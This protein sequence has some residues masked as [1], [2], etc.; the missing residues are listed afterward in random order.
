VLG[1]ADADAIDPD[2]PFADIGFDSLT[3]VELRNRLGRAT[4]LRLS[5]TLVFDHPTPAALAAHLAEQ[6]S[7][8]APVTPPGAQRAGT[9]L[10]GALC[11]TAFADG[12]A[13][14]AIGVL[15]LGTPGFADDEALVASWRELV[16]GHAANVLDRFG[17]A[18]VVLAGHSSGGLLAYG[19]A[20]ELAARGRVPRALVLMDTY[21]PGPELGGR[22]LSN[23]VGALFERAGRMRAITS[24][25]LSAM[26]HYGDR[27]AGWALAPLPDTVPV[28]AVHAARRLAEGV[29]PVG[30]PDTP[31]AALLTADGDHFTML[32][33][34]NAVRTG[35]AVRE[36]LAGLG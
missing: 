33:G 24:G 5:A 36:W 17:D 11:R 15:A 7:P 34:D 27:A 31:G 32:E 28:L 9:D 8:S 16:E 14:R 29:E 1:H 12:D 21:R 4:G 2:V 35:H 23:L 26:V 20:Q 25:G 6:R 30:A 19:I 3:A 22:F 13:E 18:P 10:V